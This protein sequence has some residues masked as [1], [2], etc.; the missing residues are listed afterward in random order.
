MDDLAELEHRIKNK[1][2]QTKQKMYETR[3]RAVTDRLWPERDIEL[4]IE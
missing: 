1:I 2:Q 3:E 4:G